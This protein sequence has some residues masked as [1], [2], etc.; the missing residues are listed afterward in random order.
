MHGDRVHVEHGG[1]MN[2]RMLV[3][4][5]ATG[6]HDAFA[7]LLR[8]S[9]P[10]VD[11]IARL[12]LRDVDRARDAA[13]E[14][15]IR[16]WRDL[17]RLR[18]PERFDAWIHRLT[19]HA[20]LDV[21]ERRQRQAVEVELTAITR[22]PVTGDATGALADR[23]LVDRALQRLPPDQRALVI[24]RFHLDLT[25]PEAADAL[26]IPLGTA[27]SRLHRALNLLRGALTPDLVPAPGRI[28]AEG[29]A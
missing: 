7:A 18:D 23:D 15:C 9:L 16:A 11:A 21:A 24:L 12:M 1:T 6:D 20:C 5:A 4:R 27:K 28:S 17:P 14:A 10:R 25:L 29:P 3:E 22:P 2:Q 26:G 13:Q 19:V 8:G